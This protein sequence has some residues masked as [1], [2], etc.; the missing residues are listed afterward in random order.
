[1]QEH[2]YESAPS[3]TEIAYARS[4]ARGIWNEGEKLQLEESRRRPR[5]GASSSLTTI[6][7]VVVIIFVFLLIVGF[8]LIAMQTSPAVH[9][10]P[11]VAPAI[12]PIKRP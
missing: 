1:M 4:D 9:V 2:E 3:Q 8:L 7:V 6:I 10:Y 5:M 11:S 12:P